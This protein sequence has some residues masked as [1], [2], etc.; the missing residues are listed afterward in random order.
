MTETIRPVFGKLLSAV[1]LWGCLVQLPVRLDAQEQQP[2]S[3]PEGLVLQQ[4]N[5]PPTV[6]GIMR[7]VN[8]KL[9]QDLV[10]DQNA[11]VFLVQILGED[12]FEES[13]KADSLEMLGIKSLSP[14]VAPFLYFQQF[15]DSLSA[16]ESDRLSDELQALPAQ[17]LAGCEK[18]W[19][20]SEL[21]ALFAY[22]NA[23]RAPLDL[24]VEASKKPRY[25]VPLLSEEDPPQLIS[26][27]LTIERRLPFLVRCLSARALMRLAEQTPELAIDDL[28]ACQ[29][30]AVL[31]AVGSPFDLSGIKAHQMDGTAFQASIA[32]LHSGDL[33]GAAATHYLEQ[34]K[35]VKPLPLA[36]IAAD[37]GERAVLLRQIELLKQ[38]DPSISEF[39]E[40]P[41]TEAFQNFAMIRL[42][43]VDLDRVT[44]R[45]EEIHDQMVKAVSTQD[46]S[47]QD[48]QFAE[49][50]EVFAKWQEK[51]ELAR[52]QPDSLDRDPQ[53]LGSFIGE[54][55]A[56][57]LRPSYR[58]RRQFDDRGQLRR[59]LLLLSLA[60]AAYRGDH[61]GYP[62]KLSD[63]APRYLDPI[64]L[65]ATGKPFNYGPLGK[66]GVRLISYGPNL[67]NDAGLP[68][69][70]DLT[71]ELP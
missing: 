33:K 22:L 30:L 11:A 34:L 19:K 18:P 54:T 60:L 42:S 27:S 5:I 10:P 26:V 67:M 1:V 50:D 21:P 46:R 62:A 64:P 16:T 4:P 57:S 32:G 66:T 31:L 38:D 12:V 29:R 52:S 71:I 20:S 63:L 40:F 47:E 7:S 39:F 55:M 59:E 6:T 56:M 9:A 3:L 70:D 68:F 49:L 35:Q 2:T 24:A 61:E 53:S 58:Q 8:E 36:S 44:S 48:R 17:L 45:A 69:N 15:A 37:Q 23:N 25:Y 14:N 65:D 43:Q 13:L 51:S 28:L 41:D